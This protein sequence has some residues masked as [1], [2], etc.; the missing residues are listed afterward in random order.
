MPTKPTLLADIRPGGS[1]SYGGGGG[2][3]LNRHRDNTGQGNYNRFSHL[4]PRERLPSVGKRPLSPDLAPDSPMKL[5]RLDAN[6]IFDQLSEQDKMT[7]T[8]KEAILAAKAAIAAVCPPDDGGLGTAIHKLTEVCDLLIKNNENL[9]ST[10]LDICKAKSTAEPRRLEVPHTQ[11]GRSGSVNNRFRYPSPAPTPTLDP[12]EAQKEKVKKALREAERRTVI[13]DLNLGS[14]PVINKET[15]SRKVSLALQE[16]ARGGEHDYA[17][18]DA[19]EMVDDTLSCSMLEFLGNGTK[20]FYNNQNKSDPRNGKMCTVPVR[21]DFKNKETRSQAE[22]TLRTICKVSCS[23]PYPKK[24]RALLGAQI[25]EGKKAFPNEKV[26]IKN[27]VDIDNLTISTSA[28]INNVWQKLNMDK[29]IPLDI[30]GNPQLSQVHTRTTE[31]ETS[32]QADSG[33]QVS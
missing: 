12:V 6:K 2:T 32:S 23:V 11:K 20:K 24:L 9:K 33:S 7:E 25:L 31:M 21:L 14:A 19:C 1:G 3:P 22:F 4:L 10:M 29:V 17:I 16:K 8:A 27:K 18:N 15:I 5:P 13:F 26:F 30:M 28:R